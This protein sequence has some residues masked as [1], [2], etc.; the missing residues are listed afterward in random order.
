M[1]FFAETKNH[2]GATRI[3]ELIVISYKK[4]GVFAWGFP[5]GYV[6][7]LFNL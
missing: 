7:T 3:A 2:A 5:R 6:H 1:N 4:E